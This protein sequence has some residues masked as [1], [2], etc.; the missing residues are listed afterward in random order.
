MKEEKNLSQK[1]KNFLIIKIK[2]C[3]LQNEYQK[4]FEFSLF[5]PPHSNLCEREKF[6]D[7]ECQ[8]QSQISIERN[9]L[10][11]IIVSK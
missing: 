8:L 10:N 11:E 2:N 3:F 9:S 7:Y 5:F 1:L 4:K 6:H